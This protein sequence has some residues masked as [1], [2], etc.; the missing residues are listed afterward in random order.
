MTN[1]VNLLIRPINQFESF[2]LDPA[3][4]SLACFGYFFLTLGK[5]LQGYDG[6]IE[7]TSF[8]VAAVGP[9]LIGIIAGYLIL[10]GTLFVSSRILRGKSSFLVSST[11][12]GAS[13]FWP[14]LVGTIGGLLYVYTFGEVNYW[15]F[16][17]L[18]LVCG[19]WAIFLSASAIK[20]INGFTWKRACSA[21]LLLLA[22]MILLAVLL[23]WAVN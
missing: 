7:P 14:M 22:T 18:W 6:Q 19:L 12:I 15:F 16:Y 9:S 4:I 3:Y 10:G 5:V 17:T 23:V 1:V 8:V 2:R 20:D 21:W 11:A 13:Y